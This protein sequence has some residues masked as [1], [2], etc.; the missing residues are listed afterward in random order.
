MFQW[1]AAASAFCVCPVSYLVAFQT[2]VILT[3]A[4]PLQIWFQNRR[5][6]D[7]RRT[8]PLS[9]QDIEALAYSRMHMVPSSDTTAYTSPVSAE[10]LDASASQH[11]SPDGLPVSPS[12]L[13]SNGPV[14]DASDDVD[15]SSLHA[16]NTP[17]PQFATPTTSAG[18]PPQPAFTSSFCYVSNR[19]NA[20]SS[21]STPSSLTRNGDESLRYE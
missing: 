13:R 12:I 1:P 21:F 8:Q 2:Q 9:P 6:N 10:R 3:T 4:L 19:W 14:T 5:Q 11:R 16:H 7:R 18:P 15:R 17:S 20:R